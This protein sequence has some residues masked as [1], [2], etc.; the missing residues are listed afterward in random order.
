[1][2]KQGLPSGYRMK[3]RVARI[4]S[5]LIGSERCVGIQAAGAAAA[6][7]LW[8]GHAR[9]QDLRWSELGGHRVARAPGQRAHLQHPVRAG[10]QPTHCPITPESPGM[11]L[12]PLD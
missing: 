11:D 12:N 5:S 8:P 6:G 3:R 2:Y 1:M 4:P 10:G 9:A 7:V